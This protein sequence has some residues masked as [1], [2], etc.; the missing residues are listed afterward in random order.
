VT[1]VPS[2]VIP[3]HNE[4]R[5]IGRLLDALHDPVASPVHV[6]VVCNGCDDGTEEVARDHPLRPLVLSLPHGSKHQALKEGDS[7]AMG[8]PRFYVDADVVLSAQSLKELVRSLRDTPVLAVA[9]VRELDLSASSWPVRAYYRVWQQLPA[10]QEGLFGRGVIGVSRSGW[11]RLRTL[12]DVLGDDLWV[13]AQFS[14]A[15]RAIVPG[16]QS[17]VRAPRT[18]RDLLRRRIRAAQGNSQL[19]GA[20]AHPV[21]GNSPAFVIHGVVRSPRNIV[22]TLVFVAVTVLARVQANHRDPAIWLRDE[23]SRG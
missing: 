4:A 2:V 3:A 22:D 8:F 13:A 6:V 23:S 12:P 7:A 20:L 16:A 14:V 10:V 21:S 5:V 18:T 19:R 15:E 11:K 9:P 17:L 1:V